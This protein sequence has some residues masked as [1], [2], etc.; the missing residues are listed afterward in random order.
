MTE[1]LDCIIID[2]TEY[3]IGGGASVQFDDSDADLNIGDERGN[4]IAQFKNGHIKTKKYD[5]S[6]I[7]SL[8]STEGFANAIAATRK[9]T[10]ATGGSGAAN[11]NYDTIKLVHIT[12]T[13]GDTLRVKNAANFAKLLG[14]KLIGT[15]D[16][17]A[18]HSVTDQITG[19]VEVIKKS[20]VDYIF[21]T[22]NHDTGNM[23]NENDCYEK[24]FK[25]FEN[26]NMVFGVEK[27]YYYVDDTAKKIRY[28]SFNQFQTTPSKLGFIYLVHQEQADFICNAIKTIPAG[29]GLI[30]LMHTPE[31]KPTEKAPLNKFQSR[32][33]MFWGNEVP[34]KAF[35]YDIIDAFIGKTTLNKSYSNVK[36]N[37]SVT[38]DVDFSS[39]ASNEFIC[40]ITGHLH[41]DHVYAIP[42]RTHTQIMLNEV[43]TNA[44]ISRNSDLSPGT[45]YP[46]Y[47]EI[48]D[49]GRIEGTPCENAVN[50]YVIDREKG[51]IKIVRIGAQ[52]PLDFSERRDYMTIQYK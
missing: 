44:W 49:L 42:D 29:Y 11:N 40:Y 26:S 8:S 37:T 14:A 23:T 25:P 10:G 24:F 2:D 36:D 27:T 33:P 39:V 15:G 3:D 17:V 32:V 30:V 21:C 43:C 1:H 5:S 34:N 18:Y 31:I 46:Y 28:L 19:Q 9:N 16:F 7:Y 12:D 50:C 4:V 51:I 35:M 38:I 22:G 52:L 20:G 41:S 6:E 48:N 13:H 45:S 47:N